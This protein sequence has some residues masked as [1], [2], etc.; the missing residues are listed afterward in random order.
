M[1]RRAVRVQIDAFIDVSRE[2]PLAVTLA[3]GM[4]ANE[5]MWMRWWRRPARLG[6]RRSA[7]GL[8]ERSVLRLAGE[9]LA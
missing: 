7:A 6:V 5:R 4:P 9:L 1:G 8:R 2:L 3:V